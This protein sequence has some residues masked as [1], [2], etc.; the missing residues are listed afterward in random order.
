MVFADLT[1]RAKQAAAGTRET[2]EKDRRSGVSHIEIPEREF[3]LEG[4]TRKREKR[5]RTSAA[6]LQHT[7]NTTVS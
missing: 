7:R 2:G 1:R 6:T 5:T 3:V 4:F